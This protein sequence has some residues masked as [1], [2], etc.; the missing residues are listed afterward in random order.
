MQN[1]RKKWTKKALRRIIG[2]CC[3]YS[4]TEE[5]YSMNRK[6]KNVWSPFKSAFTLS[7]D[8]DHETDYQAM[9]MLIEKFEQYEIKAAFACIGKWIEK[10]PDIHKTLISK[11]H[12]IVNHTYTHPSNSHFHPN[13]RFNQISYAQRKDEI[14]RAD[15]TIQKLL[16]YQPIGFR[17]P[18]FGDSHTE[19]VYD[20]LAD[21]GYSYSTSKIAIQTPKFGFPYLVNDTIWEFP[22]SI[23]PKKIH[24]CFD[25]YNEF[26]KSSGKH[27]SKKEKLFFDRLKGIVQLGIQ[28]NSYINIYFDP[29]DSILLADF[30]NFLSFLKT[31][32]KY[33]W[34]ATYR[35]ILNLLK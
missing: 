22:L 3:P 6:H 13:E 18:H 27:S 2:I 25:T 17:T 16:C 12:E 7:F 20:I 24:T 35:E 19:D 15:E 30:E 10:Y 8:C 21:I 33:L 34:I 26:K 4:F 28:T 1:P 14:V 29:S 32:K 31:L 11:G 23:D 9:P 5:Y